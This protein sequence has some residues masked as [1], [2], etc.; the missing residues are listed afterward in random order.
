MSSVGF[1]SHWTW[2]KSLGKHGSLGVL[3][4]TSAIV[5]AS[6]RDVAQQLALRILCKAEVEGGAGEREGKRAETESGS[7]R[8]DI[9]TDGFHGFQGLEFTMRL[10]RGVGDFPH[11]CEHL[12]SLLISFLGWTQMVVG[13]GKPGGLAHQ[14]L[15]HS[16]L[17]A[18]CLRSQ[19]TTVRWSNCEAASFP[20]NKEASQAP[21]RLKSGQNTQAWKELKVHV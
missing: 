15:W 5:S 13:P 20:L 21:E 1:Y 2:G 3:S 6:Q 14:Y 7:I 11:S 10:A 16:S 12:L 19:I 18:R 17:A 8:G 4:I 9:Q